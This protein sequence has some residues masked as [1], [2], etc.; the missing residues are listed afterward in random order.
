MTYRIERVYR[1][2]RDCPECGAPMI[3]TAR[4]TEPRE[5]AYPNGVRVQRIVVRL[6]VRCC[7][8]GYDVEWALRRQ[9]P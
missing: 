7:Y 3:E 5:V 8:C 9:R 6:Q 4:A 2:P 1:M